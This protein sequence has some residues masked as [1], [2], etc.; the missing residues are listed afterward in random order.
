MI[1]YSKHHHFS[2]IIWKYRKNFVTLPR[3]LRYN[4]P[5]LLK[6][7]KKSIRIVVYAVGFRRKS[8]NN[9]HQSDG[10][11]GSWRRGIATVIRQW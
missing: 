6:H 8:S 10:K 7:D 2:Y 4:V 3:K 11:T 1:S 5:I 9:S